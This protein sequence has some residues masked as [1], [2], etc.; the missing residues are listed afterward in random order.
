M[1]VDSWSVSPQ[2][3]LE[4]HVEHVLLRYDTQGVR[5]HSEDYIP[6]PISHWLGAAVRGQ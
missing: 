1:Y 2:R 4:T 5:G 3:N 6:T